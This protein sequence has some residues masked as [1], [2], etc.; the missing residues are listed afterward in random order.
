MSDSED[1]PPPAVGVY[2][3]KEDDYPALL[4][5]FP[6]GTKMPRTWKEWLRMAEEMEAGLKAYGHVVMRVRIEPKSYLAWC[7]AHNAS[8]GAEGRR[9]FVAAAVAERYGNQN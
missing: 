3:I 5:I 2:W 7:A 9:K 6:D 1:K 4:E 8:P